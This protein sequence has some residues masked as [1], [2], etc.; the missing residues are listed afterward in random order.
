MAH[1]FNMCLIFFFLHFHM[2]VCLEQRDQG[3]LDVYGTSSVSDNLMWG[4]VENLTHL[5]VTVFSRLMEHICLVN[6]HDLRTQCKSF[7]Y[8]SS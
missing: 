7:A 4:R 1:S 6:D 8:S 2:R 5:P 3:V